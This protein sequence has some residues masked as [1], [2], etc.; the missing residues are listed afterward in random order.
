MSDETKDQV[1]FEV[2]ELDDRD[3]E[4]V[5]GGA[6]AGNCNCSCPEPSENCNCGCGGGGGGGEPTNNLNC[7]PGVE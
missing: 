6:E 2:T 5:A 1:T 7:G 3:L 4:D